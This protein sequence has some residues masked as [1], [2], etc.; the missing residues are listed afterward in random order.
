V[1]ALEVVRPTRGYAKKQRHRKQ[2]ARLH[3]GNSSATLFK[4][5]AN[6]LLAPSSEKNSL[7]HTHQ[8]HIARTDR[9]SR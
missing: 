5:P 1:A 4:Q 2:E 3:T 8:D 7:T 9:N 6:M